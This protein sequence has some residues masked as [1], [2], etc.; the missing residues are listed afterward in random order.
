MGVQFGTKLLAISRLLVV[1]VAL[2][3]CCAVAQE[4]T[5]SLTGRLTDTHS[6]PLENVNITLRN[7]I[8]G[9]ATRATTSR[10]GK[11]NFTNVPQ[12]EYTLAATGPL[13]TGQ[14][15]GI[16]VA[17]GHESRVQTA[18]EFVVP[19]IATAGTSIA[20]KAIQPKESALELSRRELLTRL[21]TEYL[22]NP[23]SEIANTS[24]P[25]EALLFLPVIRPRENPPHPALSPL[26]APDVSFIA[27]LKPVSLIRLHDSV[28]AARLKS[29]A[30]FS[31]AQMEDAEQASE[32]VDSVQLESLPTTR[33][34]TDFPGDDARRS[35]DEYVAQDRLPAMAYG[36]EMSADKLR[37]RSAFGH[38][39]QAVAGEF[40]PGESAINM[41][42]YQR[43]GGMLIRQSGQESS[44]ISTRRGT[45]HLHGQ[46]SLFNRQRMLSAQNPFT[47]WVAET[48]PASGS[49][50]PT[51][52]GEPYTPSDVELRWGAG[53]GGAFRRRRFF[54][55]GSLDGFDRSNSAVAAVRHPDRFFAQPSNDQM[56]L[57]SAQLGLSSVDPVTE[58]VQ[59]YSKLLESLAGLLGP[60]P[61]SS[62][63]MSG[64]GRLDWSAAERHRFTMEGAA[65]SL[66][67]PG[68]GSSRAW[69]PYGTHSLGSVGSSNEWFVGRWETFETPKL[70]AITYASF[71]HKVQKAEPRSPSA[72]EQSLNIN[73]WGQLPQIVVDSGDG[74]TIGNPAG[75]GRGTYPNESVYSFQ[76]QAKWI[77]GGVLLNLGGEF[78]H[79][80]DA[81]TR[82]HNQTGTYHYSSLGDFASDAL[83]FFAFGLNGQL[84]PM[85]QHNCD[86]RGRP[87]RDS[88]GVL[89]GLGYLPCYSYYSQTM[90]PS[91]WWLST[92]DWAGYATSQWKPETRTAFSLAFRWELEQLPPPIPKLDNPDLPLTQHLPALGN[93]WGPRVGFAWGASES[94]WPV[95]RLGYG[96]YFG[97]AP[98][99]V[100]ESA[101]TQTGSSKGDLKFFMRPTD[102]LHG[103]GAPPFP[104]VLAGEPGTAVKPGVVEFA[105]SFHNAEVHQA[106]LSIEETLPGHVHFEASGFA[107]LGRRLPVTMDANIDPATNPKT[108][109]Y[110]VLDANGSGPIKTPQITVPLFASWPSSGS[111][112]ASGGRLNPNYEQVSEI[113]S[114]ANSTSQAMMVRVSRNGHGLMFRGRY[115]FGHAA[116]WN[117]DEST[118]INGPS[119]LDPTDFRQEYGTSDLDVRHSAT[120]SVILQPKWNLPRNV[121]LFAKG[122]MMSGVGHFRSG[123]PY[124]MRTAGSLP[125][126]FNMSGQAI[127]GLS[128]G[129]NGYGGDN[130]VYG[131]GRNTYRY[132][133]TWKADLRI[134]KRFNLGQMRQ[135][136]LMAESF[137][138]F[139]HQNVTQI[140]TVGYSIEQGTLNGAMPRINFLTGLKSGQ[141]EFGK[142]LDI[143]A[144]DQYRQR[145]FQFGARMRF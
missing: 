82:L 26:H 72:F 24:F 91:E 113:F 94:R 3:P 85:G 112:S 64:F 16:V 60:A 13:G 83:P 125:K 42:A 43:S 73:S 36:S 103:G 65:S 50:V 105:P 51:F 80:I 133:A 136:E 32:T 74:F 102:N 129:M 76:Q 6:A 12:G 59:A 4:P 100:V 28:L 78:T 86:Q 89:H 31:A 20:P 10:G 115:A 139:N 49:K 45:E 57:L 114:K 99:A 53:M 131:I 142:P 122:W 9:S 55:F 47:Q 69:Q 87:W 135:L 104:Y 15:G 1:A 46:F 93:Q 116:D 144:T 27:E 126:E 97:R 22:P 120:A 33:D 124:T 71:G 134:A 130:R 118:Q 37:V 23:P 40:S 123:L 67:A 108:I 2:S 141:T 8:T 101:L 107:S 19:G 140:E 90:G 128:T 35:P 18:I 117:P 39:H 109:T 132:P 66:N 29:K 5:G 17:P 84:N 106:E 119:V 30:A 61:R 25:T 143:N 137:N 54:W 7:V 98:N 48:A 34:W 95:I 127:V 63:Q 77:H 75:F 41:V 121:A 138:L 88:S 58:G 38:V 21:A 44:N 110:S 111:S 79:E 52:A 11:Y 14:V 68:G 56:Q 70:L 92:N 96:M 62:L 81:T 145:Q